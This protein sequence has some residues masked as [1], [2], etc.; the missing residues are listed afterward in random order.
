MSTLDEV[1]AYYKRTDLSMEQKHAAIYQTFGY[2]AINTQ[3]RLREAFEAAQGFGELPFCWNWFLTVQDAP[4][5]FRFLEIGVYKGRTLAQVQLAADL[6]EKK[7]N[8]WGLT[9][10]STDGDKYSGYDNVDYFA[11]IQDSFRSSGVNMNNTQ[12]IRGYSQDAPSLAEA[13]K[14]GPF[15][16]LYIDGCHDYEVV[17]ADIDNYVPLLKQG[18]VLVMDDASLFLEAPGGLFKGH[19][20]VGRAIQDRLD[21]RTDMEHLFAVG[22]N[23]VWRKG[24]PAPL[25]PG[26]V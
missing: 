9:P 22:H 5:D 24:R 18:G 2:H 8:L 20:D 21:G 7:G 6:L 17:C 12:I 19:P 1:A 16:I 4:A 11:A 3:P 10:L 14:V 25:T 15:D 23:R 13:A 26:S